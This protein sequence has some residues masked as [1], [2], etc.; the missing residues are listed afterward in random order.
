M[1]ELVSM[2]L[3]D[4]IE[5]VRFETTGELSEMACNAIEAHCADRHEPEPERQPLPKAIVVSRSDAPWN[6]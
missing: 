4:T 3:L 2:G 6:F 1:V 5:V